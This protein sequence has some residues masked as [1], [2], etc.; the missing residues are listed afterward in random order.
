MRSRGRSWRRQSKAEAQLGS[1]QSRP[2]GMHTARFKRL[3]S[4]IWA[5]EVL[6]DDA[7]E[8]FERRLLGGRSNVR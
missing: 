6:R 1:G 3:H 8:A 5:C 2:K 7:V 4:T